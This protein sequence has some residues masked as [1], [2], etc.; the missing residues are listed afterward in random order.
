V[1][2]YKNKIYTLS[3][4]VTRMDLELM[5]FG[6]AT[7]QRFLDNKPKLVYYGEKDQFSSRFMISGDTSVYWFF[8]KFIVLD[9]EKR[10]Q[11]H[12]L[13]GIFK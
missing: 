6:G 10:G 3:D 5:K 2:F 4:S 8:H 7:T 13:T 1:K 9:G 11:N 12:P